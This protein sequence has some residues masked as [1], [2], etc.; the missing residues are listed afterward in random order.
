VDVLMISEL[1]SGGE[2]FDGLSRTHLQELA[3]CG[4]MA[5]FPAGTAILREGERADRFFVLLKGTVALEAA[6]PERG[7]LEIQTLAPGDTLG[8][9]WLFPPHRWHLDAIARDAVVAMAFDAACVRARCDAD[10][11]LGHLL[12]ARFADMML[13]RLMATRLQLLDVYAHGGR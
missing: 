12:M 8:W 5:R 7:P 4:S 11:E 2:M 3:R 10:H 9:S 13:R 1:V 6:S